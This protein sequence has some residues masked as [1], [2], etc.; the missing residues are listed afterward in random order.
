MC[1]IGGVV[2]DSMGDLPDLPERLAAMA[3][4]MI[5]RGPDD[6]GQFITSNSR[7][8]LVNRRLAIRD[9]SAA[10]HMPMGNAAGTVWIT[11]NGEIYNTDALRG[12][13]EHAGYGFRSSSDTEVILHGYEAWGDEV[14]ARL[15]GMFALAILRVEPDS[16]QAQ[17]LLLA[18][19]PLGIK[20]LYYTQTGGRLAFASELKA[21]RAARL[22]GT[23]IEPQA[24]A[25]YLML[26]AVPNPL[27]IYREAQALPPGSLLKWE[28]GCITQRT[29][30][31]LPT[32]ID[33]GVD[34]AEAL[35]TV[36][37]ALH[38]A[39]RI[40]LVSDVPLGAFLSG[41]LDS[42]AIVA[43]MRAATNGTLRTCSMVFDEAAYNEAPFARAMAEAVGAEHY[44]RRITADDVRREFA[45]ILHSLDQPSID[46][47]NAYFVSQTARQAGLT[48]ALSGL[49][50]DELFGG[51]PN[52]FQGVPQMLRAIRWTQRVPGGAR[53][54]QAGLRVFA[55]RQP[56]RRVDEA[57]GRP[58]SAASAYLVRRGL[59]SPGEV[60]NLLC[61]DLAQAVTFDPVQH[62]A[63]R[64]GVAASAGPNGQVS[65]AV[66]RQ[67]RSGS[68]GRR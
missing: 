60:P 29:Y 66:T 59:F 26:G 3:A 25:G 40:R 21:L 11:Y 7:A 34:E 28:A 9:L 22:I 39:V 5:H 30:W 15:R 62:V 50:G 58:A 4:A 41:G 67:A 27:T 57:L 36:R 18:R 31:R 44:E 14:V 19:D 47:V 46:G 13:L 6:G 56:W 24:L 2:L 32:E 64:A 68:A 48:V 20:P 17:Q 65:R 52:T 33:E 42:S 55:R 61:A 37:A 23:E 38:E 54:V 51:Y 12:E 10:G 16:G 45:A 53:A 1:G 43:L 63:E 49:G 35:E 8:G